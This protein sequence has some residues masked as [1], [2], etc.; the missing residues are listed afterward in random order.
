MK[1]S[2]SNKESL[3]MEADQPLITRTAD[4]LNRVPFINRVAG[5]LTGMQ[6][7]EGLVVGIHGPWGDGKTT[8][9]NLLRTEL[10]ADQ[11]L[12]VRDFNPWRLTDE[13]AMLRQFFT[14][15]SDAIGESLQTNGEHARE[16]A[17]KWAERARWITRPVGWFWKPAESI[18]DLLARFSEGV[19]TGSALDIDLLRS[20]IIELLQQT[21]RRIIILVDD[22]DRLDKVEIRTLFRVIKAGA[23]FPNVC[24]VL[25]FD[26]VI[27]AKSL[28][29]HYGSSDEASGRA[30]LEKIIQVPLK[31]PVAM[32]EDLRTICF[33]QVDRAIRLAG[34][35]L[36]EQEAG[37]FASSFDRNISSRLDTARA[38]KRFGNSLLFALP[39]LKG[40][41]DTVDLLLIEA[42]RS[43]YP[44][45]YNSISNNHAEFSGVES[46]TMGQTNTDSKAVALLKPILDG[47]KSNEQKDLKS[48]LRRLFPRLSRAYGSSGYGDTWLERWAKEKRIC[49]P[50]YC[51]RY[52]SYAV[53]LDDVSDAYI[54][55]VIK[56]AVSKDQQSLDQALMKVFT[57]GKAR[58]VIE[59][60]RQHEAEIPVDAVE[61]L[62][63]AFAINA[64]HIPNPSALF[65]HTQPPAQ[66][67]MLIS[68]LIRLLPCDVRVDLALRVMEVSNPMWFAGECLRWMYVTD[69]EDKAESN[70]LKKQQVDEVR[71]SLTTRIR[72]R[73]EEGDRLFDLT[74]P[75]EQRLLYE[76]ARAEGRD[77]VQA[78]LAA[79]FEQ[80]PKSIGT[81]LQTMAPRSWG[82]G[83]AVPSVGNIDGNQF[84]NIEHLFDLDEMAALI[85]EHL[86][87]N[88]EEEASFFPNNEKPIEQQLA[89]QFIHIWKQ[90]KSEGEPSDSS[91]KQTEQD[92][93]EGVGNDSPD[94]ESKD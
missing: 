3:E 23:S 73:S 5:I 84:K 81:F 17:G 88:F 89:E 4:R 47:L 56:Q 2:D 57:S 32:R 30:F 13:D 43:F 55:G 53:S 52:F 82:N 1:N 76:W 59:R 72:Q 25:A 78:H 24:Y 36:S 12:V 79:I 90:W 49:S 6:K 80:D 71:L 21:N 8:V 41:V 20:R 92:D 28:G 50:S 64:K 60:L 83:D 46:E 51:P 48:L 37:E 93:S 15:L 22:I 18:D 77:S 61:C 31:L 86:S 74:I 63:L 65:S 11:S 54:D 7:G 26:D 75:Q 38:A 69:E 27:V 62:V 10:K 87:G 40:E 42:V 44:E 67:A 66:A 9:L 70:A 14:M 94:G 45:I 85:Q 58:R 91:E 29:E 34:M 39:M 33:E 68:N 19:L 35:E 16:S